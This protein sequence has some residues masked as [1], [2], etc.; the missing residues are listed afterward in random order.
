MNGTLAPL[1]GLVLAGGRSSRM[2][3]DKA[4]L[5]FHGK[6][7]LDWAREL[8]SRHCE[9]VFVSIRPDQRDDPLRQGMPVVTDIHPGAGPIAGIAAAQASAPDHAW[10]V[11]A[12]DLPFVT[13]AVIDALLAHRDGR[14]VVAFR[15]AHDGL[16][17]PLCAIYEPATRDGI[18]ESITS[19]RNCP[20]K[21]IMRSGV[22]LLEQPQA[23]ALDNVNTPE[24]LDEAHGRL[25]WP[26]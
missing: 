17:E 22:A 19:G 18:L 23:T 1:H 24:E 7:Q 26:G 5:A 21:F 12:C 14:P 20:R 3:H 13:D 9:R 6:T 25:A 15:S 11:L 4:A 2:G 16:P 10:L 8:L